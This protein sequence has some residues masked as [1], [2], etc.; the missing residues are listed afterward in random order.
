MFICQALEIPN[1]SHEVLLSHRR[2]QGPKRSF[3]LPL[4]RG[5]CGKNCH[6]DYIINYDRDLGG[7]IA[8]S[9]AAAAAPSELEM[10]W[11]PH[12]VP[13]DIYVVEVLSLAPPDRSGGVLDSHYC[14]PKCIPRQKGKTLARLF[15]QKRRK[16]QRGIFSQP[17]P[18]RILLII[19]NR[20]CVVSPAPTRQCWVWSSTTAET[21]YESFLKIESTN[22]IRRWK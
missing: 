10:M 8:C 6:F 14:C 18:Q 1:V 5:N 13:A 19:N 12:C 4:P 2:F 11:L 21:V 7:H 3:H 17:S 16:T 22:N 15:N 20:K 9:A